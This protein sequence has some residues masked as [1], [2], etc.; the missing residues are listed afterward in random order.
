MLKISSPLILT[1]TCTFCINILTP[2]LFIINQYCPAL[3]HAHTIHEIFIFYSSG[4]LKEEGRVATFDN[5]SQVKHNRCFNTRSQSCAFN[6]ATEYRVLRF[7]LY[8]SPHTLQ[9]CYDTKVYQT[10]HIS[11]DDDENDDYRRKQHGGSQNATLRGLFQLITLSEH[12]YRA[13]FFILTPRVPTA[14]SLI[15]IRL[16]LRDLVTTDTHSSMLRAGGLRCAQLPTAT[17]TINNLL[18][19]IVDDSKCIRFLDF[20]LDVHKAIILVMNKTYSS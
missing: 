19:I 11:Q 3:E 14:T 2:L 4:L 15:E 1:R 17:V 5:Q 10:Y 18:Q 20:L 6:F 7:C 9:R 13:D 12:Y 8:V 16:M